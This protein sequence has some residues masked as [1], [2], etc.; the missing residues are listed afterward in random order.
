MGA[1]GEVIGDRFAHRRQH[2]HEAL[3]AALAGDRQHL[4]QR[5]LAAGQ[6]ERFGNPQA[7]A[8]EQRQDRGV[9][10]ALP[11]IAGDLA[12]GVE[13][14]G[15]VVDGQRLRDAVRQ[16]GRAQDGERRSSKPARGAAETGR[17][18]RSTDNPRAS[19]L[20]S[21]PSCGA[22]REIGAEI[23]G[24][25]RVY[26]REAR[27]LAQMLGQEIEKEGQIAA[28]GRDGM[29]RGAALAGEPSGPQPD[30]RAQI[31]GGREPRQRHR[32]RHSRESERLSCVTGRGRAIARS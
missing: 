21:M 26:R 29:R 20:R 4:A 30:R 1:G 27:Q 11:A 7:A 15:G 16:L 32:F 19:E 18:P 25:Q 28:I 22:S 10:L 3:L 5:R 14:A 13:R 23:G 12:G 17:N 2:R 31:V 9:A 24:A 6:P 8:I